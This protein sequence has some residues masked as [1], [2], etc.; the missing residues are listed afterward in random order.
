MAISFCDPAE[1]EH[2]RGIERLIGR[3]IT[4]EEHKWSTA[5][6]K[7]ETPSRQIKKSE[8]PQE[9]RHGGRNRRRNRAKAA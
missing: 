6:A 5:A 9:K 8:K 2:L 3:R 1:R 7:E 4:V